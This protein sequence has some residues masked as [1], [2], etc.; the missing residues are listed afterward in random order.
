MLV[1]CIFSFTYLV[2]NLLLAY[3]H[4]TPLLKHVRKVVSGFGK[5]SCFI[6]G[7]RKPGNTC[8]SPTAMI[9][10]SLAVNPLPDNKILDRSK[11]KE[12]ADAILKCIEDGK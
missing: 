4:C 11:L 3:F 9:G 10:P 5:K 12:I 1:N 6:T 8:V 7:V 2:R